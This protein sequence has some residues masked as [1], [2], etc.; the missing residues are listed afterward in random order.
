M[1]SPVHFPAD[2]TPAQPP[3]R[4]AIVGCGAV[5]ERYHLPALL[6]S[7]LVQVVG[8]VDPVVSRAQAFAARVEGAFATNS[9]LPLPGSVDLALV[10]VPNAWHEPVAVDLLRAGVHVLVEKPMA[11]T[12]TECDRMLAAAAEGHA[13]LAVGHDFRFFPVAQAAHE[14]LAAR[15]LGAIQHVDVRQSA[16]TRWPCLTPGALLPESGGGVVISFGIHTLDLLRWWLGDLEVTSYRDDC[17]GGVEA[18]C[19]CEL[20][21]AEGATLHLELSR[22]RPL[23]DTLIAECERGTIEIGI[24]EPAMIRLSLS[25]GGPP[26]EGVVRDPGF[27]EAPLVTVFTRQLADVVNAIRCGR[28]PLVDGNQG[29][30]AVALAQACYEK[31]TPLRRSWDYPEAYALAAPAVG[32]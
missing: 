17:A 22:R 21:T 27:D 13:T 1:P 8:F 26:V 4:L 28:P 3:L 23:R 19:E 24:Y 9:H 29:R 30:R 18:E 31:R 7:P 10:A 20:R 16:G 11:R 6:A 32:Q 5:T 15:P 2:I 14:L 25:S 12:V